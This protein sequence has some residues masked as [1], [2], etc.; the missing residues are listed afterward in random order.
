MDKKTEVA[1]GILCDDQ[2]RLLVG[3][4]MRSPQLG[5]W[6][7]P[8]GK[9]EPGETVVEALRREFY[10]EGGVL[11]DAIAQWAKIED[12]HFVLFLFKVFT[13]DVFIPTIYEEHRF[14]TA[15]ELP[16]LDWIDS[17]RE[18]V[19]D[20]HA[21]LIADPKVE[22]I[23]FHPQNQDELDDCLDEFARLQLLRDRFRVIS[24]VLEA[25]AL[26]F[27]D[28]AKNKVAKMHHEGLLFLAPIERPAGLPADI[29]SKERG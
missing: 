18:F 25:D 28:E 14:V 9:V 26:Q 7:M 19:N 13:H 5:K 24:C 20:L 4:R 22:E 10:E 1:I 21:I 2:G 17:N 3:R 11:L 29:L 12:K 15:A 6:E 27:P 8:G 16:G 23:V